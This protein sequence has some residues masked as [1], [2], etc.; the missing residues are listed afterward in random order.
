[1]K[2]SL[3][4]W[5]FMTLG[6]VVI[7]FLLAPL[8]LRYGMGPTGWEEEGRF[9]ESFGALNT[10]FSG[11]A[12]GAF[13]VALL[14]QQIELKEQREQMKAQLFESGFFEMLKLHHEIVSNYKAYIASYKR[15]YTGRDGFQRLRALLQEKLPVAAGPASNLEW[16][17][18]TFAQLALAPSCYLGHY[19]RNLHQVLRFAEE[20]GIADAEKRRYAAI[21]KA[22]LSDDELALVFY[23]GLTVHGREGFKPLLEKYGFFEDLIPT[24]PLKAYAR[25]GNYSPAAF[26]RAAPN[27]GSGGEA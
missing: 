10:L 7:L 22:Q 8:A 20:S 25:P 2:R 13:V 18:R 12:F 24:E 17:D 9:G 4:R 19:L 5:L 11:L 23:N 16:F 6:A 27:W 26:G 3:S 14:F 21:L 1:M 15:E